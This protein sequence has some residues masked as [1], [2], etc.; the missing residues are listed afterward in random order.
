VPWVTMSRLTR[1][2]RCGALAPKEQSAEH[3]E[4]PAAV[5]PEEAEAAMGRSTPE[6]INALSSR[7][8]ATFPGFLM[9]GDR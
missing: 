3:R 2:T 4:E 8:P 7:N 1:S 6:R 5:I 9:G